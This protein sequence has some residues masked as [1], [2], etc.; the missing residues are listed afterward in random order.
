[1]ANGWLKTQIQIHKEYILSRLGTIFPCVWRQ[2][3]QEQR[4]LADVPILFAIASESPKA[5]GLF[6][7][8]ELY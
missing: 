6:T 1:M 5:Q 8:G 4:E 3:F 7:D 2:S